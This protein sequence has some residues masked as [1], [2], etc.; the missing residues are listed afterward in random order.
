MGGYQLETNENRE[1]EDG[2]GSEG[3]EDEELVTSVYPSDAWTNLEKTSH[4]DSQNQ[5]TRGRGKNKR[6]WKYDEDPKLIEGLLDM[7]NFRA[8]KADNG[9]KPDH[10]NYVEEN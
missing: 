3:D 7:V 4:M 5:E 6:K 9:F 10:L 8:Y 1:D 2:D